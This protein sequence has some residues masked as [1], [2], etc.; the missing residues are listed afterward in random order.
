MMHAQRHVDYHLT[1]APHKKK[2]MLDNIKFEIV[3]N[4]L[5]N[6]DL[7]FQKHDLISYISSF[8]LKARFI[9]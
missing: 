8:L 2:Y 4:I 9:M 7:I 3:M 6:Q 1:P 5:N